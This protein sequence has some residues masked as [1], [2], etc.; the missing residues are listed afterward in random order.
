M[1]K[2]IVLLA[3]ICALLG[4]G[5][6]FFFR[7]NN[8]NTELVQ[9]KT[10]LQKNQ[11]E[12]SRLQEEKERITKDNDKLRSDSVSSLAINTSLQ[13]EKEKL[14]EDLQNAQK[15]L[16]SKEGTLERVKKQL[17]KQERKALQEN[18]DKHNKI[19]S[20]TNAMRKKI[21]DLE[22]T[23]QQERATY[24]YN[25]AVAYT[26]AKLYDEA[27]QAYESS[28]KFNPT[29]PDAHYNLGIIYDNIQKD[30]EKALLHYKR[31]LELKPDADDKDEVQSWIDRLK[32]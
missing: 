7:A 21:S 13:K 32:Q 28:L 18:N 4:L 11:T 3:I 12:L 14:Q 1:V 2:N 27:V 20:E 23:L 30:Q 5:G 17:E 25:L 10:M 29:S 15:I 22:A 8:L 26:E 31:Y 16:E 24:Y 19:I 6:L 9:A